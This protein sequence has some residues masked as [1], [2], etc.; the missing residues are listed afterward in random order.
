MCWWRIRARLDLLR[1]PQAAPARRRGRAGPGGS[2]GARALREAPMIRFGL[3]LLV[4]IAVT[5]V[6][7]MKSPH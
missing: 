5:V 1:L 3:G 6:V 7:T 4:G 2:E